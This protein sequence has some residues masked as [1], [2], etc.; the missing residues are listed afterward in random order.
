MTTKIWVGVMTLLT[1]VYLYL[2]TGR[3]LTLLADPNW[4]AKLMGAGMLVFPLIAAWALY[5]EIQFGIRSQRLI[6]RAMDEG[7][8][9]LQL[10][11][12]PSGRATKESAEREFDRVKAT[13]NDSWQDWLL[14]AEAYDASG[15]RR[16]A[17]AAMRQAIAKSE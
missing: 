15:D 7:L 4:I 5:R 2:M 13:F 6:S 3:A 8:S 9:E 14:L 12:R 10:E 16:R 17:R 1:L 11:L